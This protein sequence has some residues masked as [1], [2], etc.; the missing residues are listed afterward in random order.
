M[1]NN[2]YNKH[3]TLSHH[4]Y[5]ILEF[6]E[7]STNCK[8]YINNFN[9]SNILPEDNQIYIHIPF[10]NSIC[11]FCPFYIRVTAD[12]EKVYEEYVN[13]LIKE[14]ELLSLENQNMPIK[15]IYFGGGSPSVLNAKQLE[16][17]FNAL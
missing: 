8:K 7:K 2:K 13:Y 16:K 3:Y 11:M 5:P 9:V 14:M 17:L 4:F 6:H 1:S 15:A 10:C 12:K